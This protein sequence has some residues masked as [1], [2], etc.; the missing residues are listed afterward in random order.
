MTPIIDLFV[1]VFFVMVGVSINL[2]AIDITS[3]SFCAFAGVLTL[4]VGRSPRSDTKK[5]GVYDRRVEILGL[6]KAKS[7][8]PAGWNSTVLELLNE[9]LRDSDGDIKWSSK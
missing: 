1:P 4:G 6:V 5:G 7:I 2:R 8:G 3:G 9:E